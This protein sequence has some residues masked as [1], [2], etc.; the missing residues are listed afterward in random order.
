MSFWFHLNISYCQKVPFLPTIAPR[1]LKKPGTNTQTNKQTV[2]VDIDI[3]ILARSGVAKATPP[4]AVAA[5]AA[6]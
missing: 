4:L 1:S 3:D 5:F 6:T 2:F